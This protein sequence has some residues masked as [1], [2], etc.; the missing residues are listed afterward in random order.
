MSAD[1]L[2]LTIL[3]MHKTKHRDVIL[4][5]DLYPYSYG[6]VLGFGVLPNIFTG[7]TIGTEI[8]NGGG[9]KIK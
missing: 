5:Q 9:F 6:Q 4:S 1:F 2:V 3:V 8:R 7:W